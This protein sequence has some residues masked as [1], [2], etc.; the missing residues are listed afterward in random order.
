[1]GKQSMVCPMEFWY[2]QPNLI[3]TFYPPL[4]NWILKLLQKHYF[5]AHPPALKVLPANFPQVILYLLK[6]KTFLLLKSLLPKVCCWNKP[7]GQVSKSLLPP[8]DYFAAAVPRCVAQ[9]LLSLYSAQHTL[10]SKNI[11]GWMVIRDCSEHSRTPRPADAWFPPLFC[12]KFSFLLACW[13]QVWSHLVGCM[14]L[15]PPFHLSFEWW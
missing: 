8:V 1:M 3:T 7:M 11:A 6:T 13:L 15:T 4:R 12:S 5:P 9:E 14:W 10:C 2:L